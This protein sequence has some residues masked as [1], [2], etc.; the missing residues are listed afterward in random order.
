MSQEIKLDVKLEGNELIIRTGEAVKPLPLVEPRKLQIRGDFR[1]VGQYLNGRKDGNTDNLQQLALVKD[2]IIFT[3]REELSIKLI[4]NPNDSMS[5]EVIAKAQRSEELGK[6]G[7]NDGTKYRRDELFKLVRMNRIFFADY[8]QH[9]DLLSALKSFKAQTSG[10]TA[11]ETDLRGNKNLAYQ[12]EVK[13]NMPETFKLNIP[14]IKG[15]QKETFN[16]DICL[17]ESDGTASF[18]FESPELNELMTKRVEE[19]FSRELAHCE[20]FVIVNI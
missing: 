3:D 15:E 10:N 9:S 1:A 11:L 16:V 18:W 2:A 6:F 8:Q 14:I 17:E 5:T 7:I 12:K 4:T 13:S 20:G 19:M